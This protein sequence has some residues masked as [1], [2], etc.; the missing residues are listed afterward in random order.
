MLG[1]SWRADFSN[2]LHIWIWIRKALCYVMLRWRWRWRHSL[3]D[4]AIATIGKFALNVDECLINRII[5][6]KSLEV[7]AQAQHHISSF[8]WIKKRIASNEKCCSY[9][10]QRG[11]LFVSTLVHCLFAPSFLGLVLTRSCCLFSVK[12][13]TVKDFVPKLVFC[14][15][16][17]FLYWVEMIIQLLWFFFLNYY[18][19]C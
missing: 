2:N 18:R 3:D 12:W 7:F 10:E 9:L 15:P 13:F 6:S 11:K 16:F 1:V 4:Y 19:P 5:A 8:T 14:L 17:P